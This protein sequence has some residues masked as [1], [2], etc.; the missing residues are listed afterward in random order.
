MGALYLPHFQGFDFKL[1]SF[2]LYVSK[3]IYVML[4]VP[5]FVQRGGL[6]NATAI[7]VG[8]QSLRAWH[9]EEKG[10]RLFNCK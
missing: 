5:T 9:R 4:Y 8:A 6:L 7:Y 3:H 1:V 2:R 10:E